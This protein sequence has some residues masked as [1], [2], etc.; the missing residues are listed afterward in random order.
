MHF[1]FLNIPVYIHPIFWVFILFFTRIYENPNLESLILGGVVVFSLL[2]HEYGHALTAAYFGASPKINL[3]AFGGNAQYDGYGMTNKQKFIITLNGP[4]LESSLIALSYFLLKSELFS[5]SYYMQYFLTVTMKLNIYWCLLNL[6]PVA[7]LDGGQ[8]L[9]YLLERRF[10]SKGYMASL[11]IGLAAASTAALYLFSQGQFFFAILLLVF[12]FQHFQALKKS[13]LSLK[14]STPYSSYV[15][16]VQ[17]IENNELERAKRIL[18]K[19]LKSKDNKI[20]Y[21]ATESLAR[22]YLQENNDQKS[23]DL[24]LKS[25]HQ[26][27]KEGK[28]LLCKLA[29]ERKN[30]ELVGKYSNEIYEIKPSYETALLNSEAFAHLNN[31]LYSEGWKETASQF[32]K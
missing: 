17:A 7:P 4:L 23:Y 16:G 14:K 27:L 29:F 21:S 20:K 13:G 3:E 31:P 24:L 19:L 6:I 9:R 2:V 1:R 25:D 26:H 22:V 12:G 15:K 32:E 8:M 10:G 18:K 28:Y 5:H 11:F 30:Y